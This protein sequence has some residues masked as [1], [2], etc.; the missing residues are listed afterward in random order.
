MTNLTNVHPLSS[1]A[2]TMS[3]VLILTQKAARSM[4]SKCQAR[5][6]KK[7]QHG[8]ASILGSRSFAASKAAGN[9]VSCSIFQRLDQ[10]GSS[11]FPRRDPLTTAK[12]AAR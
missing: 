2:Q 12:P 6:S 7:Q 10:S 3:W 1:I 5:T 8:K 4:S 11:H 9:C